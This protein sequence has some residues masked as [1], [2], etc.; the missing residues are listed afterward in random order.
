MVLEG[1]RWVNETYGAVAGYQ[2]CAEDGLTGWNTM[3]SLTM[4]LQHELGI[5]PLAA[6][7]GP[8][9]LD[10]LT[11]RGDIGLSETNVNIINIIRYALWSKGYTGGYLLNQFDNYTAG[12]ISIL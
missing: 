6:A 1:Q 11:A 3:Y 7:F 5:S 8:T 4:G 12:Y 10:R 9:T 2:P